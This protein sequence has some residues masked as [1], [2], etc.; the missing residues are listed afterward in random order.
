MTTKRTPLNRGTNRRITPE[1][2]EA[3]RA[4]EAARRDDDD[5]AWWAAHSVLHRA[6]GLPLWEWP[7]FDYPDDRCPYPE[8]C[9]AALRWQAE[10]DAN[11]HRLELYHEL[12][13]AS[14]NAGRGASRSRDVVKVNRK[15]RS[16]R[17]FRPS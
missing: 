7:G 6:L 8:G 14:R 17:F 2:I 3:F 13:A 4:M 11:P 9:Y 1:V 12:A 5:D 15:G 16:R 10:R